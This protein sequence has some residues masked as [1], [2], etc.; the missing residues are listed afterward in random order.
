MQEAV[1]V[2]GHKTHVG[3]NALPGVQAVGSTPALL[4]PSLLRISLYSPISD[5]ELPQ[6]QTPFLNKFLSVPLFTRIDTEVPSV[7][8]WFHLAQSIGATT[9]LIAFLV[10]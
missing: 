2:P 5:W 8:L 9:S 10:K 1:P 7:H 3:Y 4:L 6:V